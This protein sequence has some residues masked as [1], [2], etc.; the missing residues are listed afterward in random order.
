VD[1]KT[2]WNTF[3]MTGKAEDY[4]NYTIIK[5]SMS[6]GGICGSEPNADKNRGNY[7][8]GTDNRGK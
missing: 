6:P 5:N 4:I 7:N 8:T 2:A 1:E 3:C